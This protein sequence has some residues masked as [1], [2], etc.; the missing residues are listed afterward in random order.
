MKYDYSKLSLK[1]LFKVE[2]A[3]ALA[4]SNKRKSKKNGDSDSEQDVE[5]GK[6]EGKGKKKERPGFRDRKVSSF[7]IH[8]YAFKN[9][10]C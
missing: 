7:K 2:A 1:K 6:S 3:S 9:N 5:E 8:V 4:E 10:L